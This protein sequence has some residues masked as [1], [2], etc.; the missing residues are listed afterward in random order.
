MKKQLLIIALLCSALSLSA[1]SH[2][3]KDVPRFLYK[4]ID[5]KTLPALK[6]RSENHYSF[7]PIEDFHPVT[8]SNFFSG[9]KALPQTAFLTKEQYKAIFSAISN[10]D[11]F[12]VLEFDTEK[13]TGDFISKKL[14]KECKDEFVVYEHT[15]EDKEAIPFSAL[16]GVVDPSL[17]LKRKALKAYLATVANA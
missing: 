15:K 13:L 1:A 2:A 6:Y 9:I 16:T 17:G 5:K 11:V 10:A 4:I 7:Y 12:L 3:G 14:S 8:F